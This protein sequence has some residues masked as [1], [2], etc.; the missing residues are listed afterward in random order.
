MTGPLVFIFLLAG[1][2]LNL[3]VIFVVLKKQNRTVKHIL[4]ISFAC[5]LLFEIFFGFIW[6]GYGRYIDDSSLELCKMAGFGATFSSLASIMHL[7]DM[8]L[9]RYISIIHP[10][11]AYQYFNNYMLGIYMVIPSWII[12]FVWAFFPFLGWGEYMREANHSYRC[13]I[14]GTSNSVNAQSYN[15]TMLIV[16]FFLPIIIITYLCVRIQMQ[17][18]KTRKKAAE[19]FKG[20][21]KMIDGRRKYEK[22][23]FVLVC[24]N[25]I[26]YFVTWAPYAISTCWYTFFNSA[27]DDVIGYSALFAKSS[28]V[29][30]PII[31]VFFYREFRE[32]L[33]AT[34][35]KK[36]T[37]P[38]V[39]MPTIEQSTEQ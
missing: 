4:V 39:E 25:I 34:L 10:M 38:S 23:H 2:I 5:C 3:L 13:S 29:T 18:V 30:N 31:Y 35:F 8:A 1:I 14:V 32:I 16:F 6:E 37:T 22:Q 12:G 27:P 11:T 28:L 36:N 24:I 9:E 19:T 20:A 26:A 33:K 15:Y 17:L 21:T 7:V